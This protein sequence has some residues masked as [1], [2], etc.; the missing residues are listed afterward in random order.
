MMNRLYSPPIKDGDM[1]GRKQSSETNALLP[2]RVLTSDYLIEGLW[3]PA[4]LDNFMITVEEEGIGTSRSTQLNSV[5]IQSTGG[6]E[7]TSRSVAKFMA[8][9]DQIIAQIPRSDAPISSY[10]YWK[11]YKKPLA[12]TFYFGP[13]TIRGSL[14]HANLEISEHIMPMCDLRITSQ[15]AGDKFNEINAP[16]ALVNTRWLI[17]YEPL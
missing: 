4:D 17:G 5:Q 14:M 12:G 11:S 1:F 3:D 9:G 13:Y 8:R 10:D 6:D 2:V 7:S 15:R 16:F